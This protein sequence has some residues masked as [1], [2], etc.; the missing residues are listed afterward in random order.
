MAWPFEAEAIANISPTLAIDEYTVSVQ[1]AQG[2]SCS[3]KKMVF[4][5]RSSNANHER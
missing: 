3:R 5:A 4:G 1:N 2:E